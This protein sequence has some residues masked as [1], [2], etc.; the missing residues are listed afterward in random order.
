MISD[1]LPI[2]RL[3]LLRFRS[4]EQAEIDFHN[5]LFL[6]GK[7]GAGKSNI[8]KALRFIS[9]C[10]SQPLESVIENQGGLN[11]VCFRS[12]T[13]L[14]PAST[15]LRLDFQIGQD[16]L[17]RGWYAFELRALKGRDFEVT[18]ESC[19]LVHPSASV[20]FDRGKARFSTNLPGIAPTVEP[21]DL[22]M[23]LLSGTPQLA[24][25]AALLKGLRVYSILPAEI[26]KSQQVDSGQV[27]RP[28]GGNV[29]TMLGHL[30]SKEGG[31]GRLL[32]LLRTVIPEVTRVDA[33]RWGDRISLEFRQ[34]STSG[35]DAASGDRSVTHPAS[36]MSDGTLRALGIL[37]AFLQKPR[38]TLLALEEPETTLHPSALHS[39][40]D[41][42]RSFTTDTQVVVTTHSPDL[43][44]IKWLEPENLRLVV[45]E[46]GRS[47]V[48]E[49]GE[50]ARS[51]MR[52]HIMGAGELFRSY[53]LRPEVRP[54]AVHEGPPPPFDLFTEVRP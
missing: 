16:P 5:P 42:A 31:K 51:V 41:L 53:A 52:D 33:R 48:L 10:M 27:L 11:V 17:T 47:V 14:R 13:S 25:V 54:A 2:R 40:L 50:A 45:S 8:L 24:P 29:A 21:R 7:N 15:G 20:H 28:D 9:D 26:Q 39:I 34:K 3:S 37:V 18:R 4:L 38:P 46:G 22:L 1:Y 32:D 12:N 23:P 35:A 19:R 30:S 36:A 44:D 43:L 6:V 49:V